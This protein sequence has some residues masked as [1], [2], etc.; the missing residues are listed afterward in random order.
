MK[1]YSGSAWQIAYVP[2]ADFVSQI[3][4]DV[5]A[6]E[7]PAGTEAQRPTAATGLLRF[8]TDAN[9]F[10]GYDGTA[11]G[12]IGGGGGASGGG[13][14]AVFYENDQTVTTN[15]IIA[16]DK[17]AMSTGPISINSGVSVTIETGARWVVI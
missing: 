11:W 4:G 6:A 10:E 5:G 14:D 13:G 9:S 16:A 17:N 7:L 8:N 2:S 15:Y 3:D 1:V 12:A